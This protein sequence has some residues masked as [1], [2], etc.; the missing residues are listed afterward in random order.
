MGYLFVIFRP[1]IAI[2]APV[3]L[4]N[5]NQETK[6]NPEEPSGNIKEDFFVND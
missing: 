1:V 2:Q 6:V 5:S 3:S 4:P